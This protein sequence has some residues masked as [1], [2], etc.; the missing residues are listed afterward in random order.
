MVPR[1]TDKLPPPLREVAG[2]LA[3]EVYLVGGAVRDLLLG[4]PVSDWDL[5][6]VHARRLAEAVAAAVGSPVVTLRKTPLVL[7]VPT[8][9]LGHVDVI[10]LPAGDVTADLMRRDFTVNALALDLTSGEVVDPAGGLADLSARVLRST[11]ESVFAQDPARLLRAYRLSAELGFTIAEETRQAIRRDRGLLLKSAPQRWGREF[12]LLCAVQGP[13]APALAAMDED[14]VLDQVLPG[15]S[16]MRGM[17]QGPYHHLDVLGHTLAAVA[18]T[19]ALI[20][21]PRKVFP[22][23][24]PSLGDSLRSILSRAILRAGVLLHDLGKPSV[25]TVDE[26][27]RIWFR[28]H[29]SVGAD[30][31]AHVTKQWGWPRAVREAVARVVRLH[32]RVLDLA[33]NAATQGREP[34]D[35][36]LRRL[37]RDA[38]AAAVVL[39][40][41]GAADLLATQGPATDRALQGRLLAQMDAMLAR[42]FAL[43]CLE[44]EPRLVSGHDLM[45]HLGIPPGRMIGKLLGA[46]EAAREE[47]KVSTV[48]EALTLA[49][50]MLAAESPEDAA[51]GADKEQ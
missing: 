3:G 46:I 6:C 19:D 7:R 27:G 47:G 29:E 45:R 15:W 42:T 35:T 13:A 1:L 4:R 38:G 50:A 26:N 49:R 10:E 8:E 17:T 33:R 31:A 40:V 11:T 36:A 43:R 30:M 5:A 14:G 48:E 44:P 9:S 28:G 20:A 16:D 24:A 2:G 25:R 12:L 18:A 23:S 34:T 22:S 51:K 39:Y 41:A 21:D 32:L 37:M